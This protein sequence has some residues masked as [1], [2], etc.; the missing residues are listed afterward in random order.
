MNSKDLCMF[1]AALSI[2]AAPFLAFGIGIII[3]SIEDFVMSRR[4]DRIHTT[5]KSFA[6]I[7][8]LYSRKDQQPI[9]LRVTM[10]ARRR[11][12]AKKTSFAV[13]VSPEDTPE[14]IKKNIVELI[15]FSHTFFD[16]ATIKTSESLIKVNSNYN[17]S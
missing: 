6:N 4:L 1:I 7:T 5:A 9:M 2:I 8:T 16:S 15:P 17:L 12:T 14:A 11:T 10:R 3:L 13:S